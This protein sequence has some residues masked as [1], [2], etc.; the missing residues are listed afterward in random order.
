M[1]SELEPQD[2][3]AISHLIIEKLKPLLIDAG[4][5]NGTGD[6]IFTSQ[7]LA[8]YLCVDVSWVY[9][10]VSNRNIP[11]FKIGKYV[12]FRKKDID[13]W[14]ESKFTRPVPTMR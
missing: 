13:K 12:R 5:S 6:V 14:L 4:K 2:I 3:E 7:D 9:K 1:K 8:K 10:S 11:Y